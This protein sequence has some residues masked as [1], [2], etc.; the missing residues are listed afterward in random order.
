MT[1]ITSQ[2]V[3]SPERRERLLGQRRAASAWRQMVAFLALLDG[4]T[5]LEFLDSGKETIGRLSRPN[6][7]AFWDDVHDGLVSA[8]RAG[9]THGPAPFLGWE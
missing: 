1:A 9:S 6:L 4:G 7:R 5:Q 3:V 2:G 8:Y